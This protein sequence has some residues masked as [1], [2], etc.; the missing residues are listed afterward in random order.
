M[1]RRYKRELY[2]K[3]VQLIKSLMPHCAIGVDVIV[4]HPGE[5]EEYFKET[6]AFLH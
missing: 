4:G 3:R 6:V 1:R 2:A 5:T